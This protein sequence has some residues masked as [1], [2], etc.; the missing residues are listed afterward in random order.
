MGMNFDKSLAA[1]EELS[2]LKAFIKII[3]EM[4]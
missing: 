2:G 4:E 3:V 1:I